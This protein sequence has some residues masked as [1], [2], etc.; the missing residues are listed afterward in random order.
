MYEYVKVVSKISVLQNHVVLY[1][2]TNGPTEV[3]QVLVGLKGVS[4]LLYQNTSSPAE[5]LQGPV[6]L[7]GVY[8]RSC[9]L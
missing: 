7:K 9:P 1:P 5:F 4:V 6:V 2:N 8:L 3:P